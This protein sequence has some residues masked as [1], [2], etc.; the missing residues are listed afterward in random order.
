M[1]GRPA[2]AA[3][4]LP[5]LT[6]AQA[7][8]M[9]VAAQ[10]LHR[11]RPTGRVDRRQVRSLLD[12]LGLVQIDSV[13]VL[14]RSHELP[15]WSRLGPHPRGALE[16]LG[17]RGEAFEYWVHEASFVPSE[18]WP[19]HRRLEPHWVDRWASRVEGERP[20]YLEAVYEEVARN[21]PLSAGELSDPGTKT[22][23]W[24]GWNHGKQA[25]ELL[26]AAG[27]L[28]VRRRR[29]FEREY[30]LPERVLPASVLAQPVPS[31]EEA[32]VILIG[33]A[34]R[35]LGVATAADLCD[36]HRLKLTRTRDAIDRLTAEGA[37]EPVEIEGWKDVAYV[38]PEAARPRAAVASTVLSPF[39]SLVFFR[40][41]VERL[42]GFRY[43]LEIYTP[44][45]KRTYGYYVL[46]FLLGDR[47]VGRLDLKSD[48]QSGVL[49]VPA[50]WAEDG[51]DHGEVA[52]SMARELVGLSAWLGLGDVD[53]AE[54]GNLADHLAK[55]VNRAEKG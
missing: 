48:R 40:P 49:R 4:R 2:T 18:Q 16:D 11:P 29:T 26:F 34:A 13:N 10:G 19:I 3:T 37:L 20:G 44:A 14:V 33:I 54:K 22:G 39:D 45:P 5:R 55:A 23:P 15:L 52:E 9:A 38:H 43:R 35:A 27:R 41:R 50:A 17:R 51:V 47:L 25:L 21:G 1:A 8:R 53:V 24:W 7:R 42:F 6:L 12:R 28:A 32:R 46:P 31:D 30:D 36:Y